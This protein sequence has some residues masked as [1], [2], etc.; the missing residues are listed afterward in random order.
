MGSATEMGGRA[1][2]N[3][4]RHVAR[5]AAGAAL[6]AGLLLACAVFSNQ[7][8]NS[9]QPKTVLE[10]LSRQEATRAYAEGFWDGEHDIKTRRQIALM[11][12]QAMH[13]R[14]P[15]LQGSQTQSLADT[16]VWPDHLVFSSGLLQSYVSAE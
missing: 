5:I 4:G 14:M 9:S 7:V 11:H 1:E 8:T 6:G 15:E 16:T 2:S 13:E 3:I 12:L 10:G